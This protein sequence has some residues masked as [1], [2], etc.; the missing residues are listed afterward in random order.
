MKKYSEKLLNVV[1]NKTRNTKQEVHVMR[2]LKQ[3]NW[4]KD[5]RTMRTEFN[6][7][8]TI[9]GKNT[10]EQMGKI[11]FYEQTDVLLDSDISL[12][13]CKSYVDDLFIAKSIKGYQMEKECITWLDM[14]CKKDYK[15]ELASDELDTQ[16]NVDIVGTLDDKVIYIQVKPESYRNCDVEAKAINKSKEKD[17]GVKVHYIYYDDNEHFSA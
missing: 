14:T 12:E 10:L 13:A 3:N 17:L 4:I 9:N 11:M 8:A 15:W 16:Y 2:F 7:Y 5:P 1:F 6:K